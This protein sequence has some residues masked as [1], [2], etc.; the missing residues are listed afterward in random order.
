[1][2]GVRWGVRGLAS[3]AGAGRAGLLA[4]GAGLGMPGAASPAG[5]WAGAVAGRLPAARWNA[6]D[7]ARLGVF[8]ALAT[9]LHIFEA[10]LPSLPIPGAKIG[11]ANLVSVFALYAWGFGEAL[12]IV[13]MR[14]LV[15]SLVTGTIFAPAFFFGLAG[16]VLSVAVMAL[17]LRLGR[18]L[19]PVAISL[20]GATAH[21]VGQ[22]LA[23]WA[24]L[25]QAQVFYYL[26]YLLWFAVPSG[27]LVGV[28]ARRLLPFIHLAQDGGGAAREGRAQAGSATGEVDVATAVATEAATAGSI[29]RIRPTTAPPAARERIA[30]EV[31]AAWLT[32]AAL[33]VAGVVAAST[34]LWQPAAVAHP[35]ARV[36][37]NGELYALLPLD[38]EGE[39][40]LVLGEERMLIAYQDGR[41]RVAESTCKNQVCVGTG[42]IGH[43]REAIACVPFQV[44][45]TITGGDAP[46]AAGEPEYDALVY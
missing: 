5:G 18:A 30:R 7:I 17:A 36:T 41:V 8:L 9:S 35:H 26:P 45:I 38:G 29:R 12:L 42:W 21:N 39:Y 4:T 3:A 10:Q 32:A 2:W 28:T 31:R 27:A 37:V 46:G 19:G 40:E 43:P 1:M 13:V 16:G 20:L 23:A 6:R 14:Q 15:G 25:G 34:M 11:L 44:L 33:V 24:M 22:L